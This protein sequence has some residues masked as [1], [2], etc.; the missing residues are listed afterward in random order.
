[1]PLPISVPPAR[2]CHCKV[3][4]KGSWHRWTVGTTI[5]LSAVNLHT[6]SRMYFYDTL[7]YHQL[8]MM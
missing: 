4:V 2:E 1:M 5:Q 8:N 7:H 6:T 3:A